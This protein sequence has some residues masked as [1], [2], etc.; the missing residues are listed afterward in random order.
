MVVNEVGY[1]FIIRGTDLNLCY[2]IVK[3]IV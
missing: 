1:K 3:H 2:F